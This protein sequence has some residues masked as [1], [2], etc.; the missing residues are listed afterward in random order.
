MEERLKDNISEFVTQGSIN[1][2]GNLLLLR[3][4]DNIR[5]SNL[6]LAENMTQYYSEID[7]FASIYANW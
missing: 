6:P 5:A 4:T 1:D 3:D 2:I 7:G